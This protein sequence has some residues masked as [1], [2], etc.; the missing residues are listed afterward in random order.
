LLF[1]NSFWPGLAS[2]QASRAGVVTTLQGRATVARPTITQPVALKFKDDLFVRDRI[3][4][5]EDSLVRVLLGGKA[6]VTIRELSVFTVTEEPG[7]AA[8]DLTSGRLAVGVAKSLLRPGEVIEIRTPNAVAGIRGSL[9]VA[10]VT[11]VGGVPQTA[12]TALQATVPITVATR[13]A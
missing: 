9:L 11:D 8:V 5:K 1:L 6:L 12:F 4:T 3:E 2:A 7:R 10:E 13:A